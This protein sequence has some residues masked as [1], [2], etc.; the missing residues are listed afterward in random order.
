MTRARACA[1][2][3]ARDTGPRASMR[4]TLLRA[5]R[6]V[7]HHLNL[8]L[9]FESHPLQAR[10]RGPCWDK[11]AHA[12]RGAVRQRVACQRRRWRLLCSPQDHRNDVLAR[13]RRG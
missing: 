12:S 5:A 1:R 11:R 10:L 13:H 7:S 6:T 3:R 9:L 8:Q 2:V 4:R